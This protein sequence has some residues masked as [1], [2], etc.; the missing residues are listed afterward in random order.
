MGV[1]PL[2]S[3]ARIERPFPDEWMT[4]ARNDVRAGFVEWSRP[5]VGEVTAHPRLGG[6]G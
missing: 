1:T 3:V 5:L 2:E 4:E 6:V